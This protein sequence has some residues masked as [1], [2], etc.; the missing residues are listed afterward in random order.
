M[1]EFNIIIIFCWKDGP[2]P[3]LWVLIA[4]FLE[5]CHANREAMGSNFLEP[6]TSP[7]FFHFNLQSLLRLL[8][9]LQQ[10]YLQIK[11]IDKRQVWE[12]CLVKLKR[13]A[14][15]PRRE[16]WW[17]YEWDRACSVTLRP[18]VEKCADT[19]HKNIQ[20]EGRAGSVKCESN[21]A[22]WAKWLT[23]GKVL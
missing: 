22:T 5:H 12:R 8:L 1:F 20:R 7:P 14:S 9:Q 21:I 6:P 2:A 23:I 13:V 11:P 15:E 16:S 3:N 4:Q 17:P 18:S 19:Y 10:L